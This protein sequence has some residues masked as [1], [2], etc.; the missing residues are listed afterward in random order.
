MKV[1][2]VRNPGA[3][4]HFRVGVNGLAPPLGIGFAPEIEPGALVR[5]AISR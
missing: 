2:G 1:K 4:C 5:P 3:S